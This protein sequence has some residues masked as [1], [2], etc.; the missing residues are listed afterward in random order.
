MPQQAGRPCNNRQCTGIVRNGTCSKCGSQRRGKDRAY[1]A[2][3]GTSAERGYDA[4]WRKLR[5]MHL[6]SEP[7]CRDCKAEGRITMGGHIHHIKAKRDGGDNSFENLMTLCA[8]HH[9][10]RTA[11]GE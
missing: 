8:S 6:A 10:Q 3:R 9:N 2:N 4:T 1:D 7:L 5:R 11:R